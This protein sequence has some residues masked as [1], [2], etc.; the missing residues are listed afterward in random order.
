M[1]VPG[2]Y[3]DEMYAESR[4]PWGFADRWYEE[5]KRAITLAALPEKRYAT[6]FEPGCSVGVFTREL[7]QRC[8][9]LLA[10]DV[11]PMALRE[12]ATRLEGHDNVR[13]ERRLLP[14]DWPNGQFDLVV[15]SEILY[16]FNDDDLREVVTR[17]SAAVAPGGTLVS[18]HWRPKVPDYPQHGDRVQEVMQFRWS[19]GARTVHHV[20]ADFDLAVYVRAAHHRDTSPL[21][22]ASKSGLR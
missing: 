1:T 6:A 4:D 14:E 12:A 20:E 19:S 18:V 17:A 22:V 10:C 2:N 13:L 5:R 8:D 16:Y 7:A 3:F 21:S 15:L 11:S 9:D